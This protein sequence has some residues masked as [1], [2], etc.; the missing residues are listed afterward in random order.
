MSVDNLLLH[1]NYGLTAG[2]VIHNCAILCR[3]G[4]IFSIGGAS[5]FVD[6]NF[7]Y[8][9]DLTD[10]YAVPGFIDPHIFGFKGFST[11]DS[12]PAESVIEMARLLPKHGVTSF[13]PSLRAAKLD[14]ELQILNDLNAIKEKEGSQVMGLHM[15]G[16]FIST[17]KRGSNP[18]EGIRP[19]D[20]KELMD[21]I[22][23]AG[24]TLKIM[25]FAPE[26]KGATRLVEIL[27]ENDIIPSMGHSIATAKHVLEAID[28]GARRCT[29]L[30]NG[31]NPLH[32]RQIG[33]ASTALVDDRI[34]V[35]LIFDGFHIHPQMI[36]LACRAK[37]RDQ[38]IAVSAATIGTGL[39][40]GEYEFNDT[41]ITIEDQHCRLED[42]TISGS[43]ITQETAWKNVLEFTHFK[44][45]NA[46][47][48]FTS[49]PATDLGL[50]DRGL[51]QPG[52]NA[53]IV[54]L[55]KNHE[56]VLT[57]VKGEVAYIKDPEIIKKNEPTP[58]DT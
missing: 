36:D 51:L 2:K 39:T 3:K 44:P 6:S 15:V 1:V 35:E 56:V 54:V 38:V 31:M 12:N 41:K 13:M 58:V 14:Q 48:C 26:I 40:D 47:S 7:D 32:Q 11:M 24:N 5:A 4:K 16:P 28:A 43:M 42:G 10:C 18:T 20:E 21:I 46:I 27:L 29:H 19:F 55:N 50:D 9:V 8:R 23:A 37:S 22:Q 52:K 34:T 49:N 33:L 30:Y 57:L 53:D 45:Q 25:T 17:A